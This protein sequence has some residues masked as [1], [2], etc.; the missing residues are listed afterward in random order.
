MF[1]NSSTCSFNCLLDQRVSFILSL[2]H[3]SIH[4]NIQLVSLSLSLFLS[5]AIHRLDRL[6]SGLLIFSKSLSKAQQMEKQIRERKVQKV[7]IAK[8]KGQFPK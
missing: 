4:P 6:T 8:V 2:V 1:I 7:Y 3:E 5:L